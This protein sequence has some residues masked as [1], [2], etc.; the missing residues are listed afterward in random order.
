MPLQQQ[1]IKN[2]SLKCTLDRATLAPVEQ[3]FIAVLHK[4][5]GNC[6][7]SRTAIYRCTA[8]QKVPL[9]HNYNSNLLLYC[10][11]GSAT[12]TQ[13]EVQSIAPLHT[14]ECHCNTSGTVFYRSIAHQKVPLQHQQNSNL[15]LYCT[16][17]SSTLAPVEEQYIAV[18][19]TKQCHSS[20]SRKATYRC[21]AHQT[22]PLSHQWNCYLSLYCTPYSATL[23]P[24]KQQSI[25]L[26]HTR[27]CHTSTSR[28]VFYRCTAQQTVPIYY[29]QNSNLSLYCTAHTATVTTVE[30]QYI[31]LLPSRHCHSSTSR[32]AI[33]SCT[34]QQTVL[35]QHQQNSNLS[36]YCTADTANLTPVE[37]QS[38]ALLQSRE[39]HQ[40]TSRT[41]IYRSTAQQ[42]VTLQHQQNSIL[43]LYCPED[44]DTVAPIEQQSIAVLHTRMCHSSTSRTANYR[45]NSKQTVSLQ[46]KQNSNLPLYCTRASAILT[47]VEQQSIALLHI[48]QC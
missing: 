7:T 19:H 32:T 41:A 34:A 12:L 28:T 31:A 26:L 29:Q 36:L 38:I 39:C 9:Q 46:H 44:S 23:T 21:T 25:A 27:K 5:Q 33:Y 40:S 22:L 8:H 24:I 47:L 1:K 48:R 42:T 6:N 30:Q 35:M 17:D 18:L 45:C 37:Q 20:T 2:L 3:Q 13:V 4:R 11:P 15:S 16:V 14:R 10:T 43:S